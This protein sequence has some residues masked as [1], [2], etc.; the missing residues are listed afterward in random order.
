LHLQ[1]GEE[2]Y[3]YLGGKGTNAIVGHNS[4]GG[5]NGGGLGTWDGG[6]D[7]SAGA[8]GGA[9]DV[10]LVAGAWNDTT[11]LASRIMVA[12]AGGGVS[13]YLGEGNAGGLQGFVP[14]QSV[15]KWGY[16]CVGTQTGGYAFGIGKD[17]NGIAYDSVG[18]SD[19]VAGGGAGYW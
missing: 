4:V 10:R 8:G 18:G 3:L 6:D 12:G 17:G 2:I 15:S 11:S 13:N 19:G 7:E 1:A 9:S 14:T 5:R 16:P